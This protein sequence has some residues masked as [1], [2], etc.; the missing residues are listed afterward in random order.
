MSSRLAD[1]SSVGYDGKVEYI[2]YVK[3]WFCFSPALRLRVFAITL[4]V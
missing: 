4:S 2:H 1:P 3:R